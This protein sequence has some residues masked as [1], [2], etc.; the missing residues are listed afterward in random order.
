[1]GKCSR[2]AQYLNHSGWIIRLQQ[3]AADSSVGICIIGVAFGVARY[4]GRASDPAARSRRPQHLSWFNSS[5]GLH[6]AQPVFMF[7]G[8]LGAPPSIAIA[9]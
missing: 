7:L 6:S 4:R 3:Q 9:L 2:H 1:M 5:S 8:G